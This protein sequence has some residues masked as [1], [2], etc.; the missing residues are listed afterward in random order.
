MRPACV[1]NDT[2]VTSV[3][4]S[5]MSMRPLSR[6]AT[7]TI[8]QHA[9]AYVS[10]RQ[11]ASAGNKCS[12]VEDEHA[13][14]V[15]ARYLHHTSACV[16]IRQHV[17]AGNK[18]SNVEDEHAP[19]VETRYLQLRRQHLY[20]STSKASKLS[21]VEAGCLQLRRQYL[22][23]CPSKASKLSKPAATKQP[24]GEKKHAP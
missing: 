14:A 19:A 15:E 16:S 11:H 3:L 4:M 18:C 9:A 23:F 6:P 24:S 8:R 17:S 12:N 22:Y 1:P 5:R 13:P 20:F 2:T 21:T 10:R 7:C